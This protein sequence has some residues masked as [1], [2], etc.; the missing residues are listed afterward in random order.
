MTATTAPREQAR[1]A[2]AAIEGWLTGAEGELLFRLAAAC[3]PGLAVVEIGSWKGKSTVWL[4]AG[5]RQSAG[6]LVFAIDP[7]EQ[8]LEDPGATTF[9]DLKRNLEQSGVAHVV[10]PIVAA[11][12]SAAPSFD[13]TPGVVFVDG[14]HMEDAVRIDLDDWFPKLVD[15]GVLALHD[16]LNQ[17]WPGPRRALRRFLWRSTDIASV[18]F[19]DSIAWMRKVRRNTMADRLRNRF[20]VGLL[21]A[22]EVRRFR[23]PAPIATFLRMIYRLTPLKG[24]GLRLRAH[25]LGL[26]ARKLFLEP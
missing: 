18:Q 5:V 13:Q 6:T 23:F 2:A 21:V 25:G 9:E 11:S 8:S 10:V 4:A 3:P 20:A 22:Y 7:H 24:D 16:V 1:A 17:R 12:H 26:N 14:S 15:G 19:V